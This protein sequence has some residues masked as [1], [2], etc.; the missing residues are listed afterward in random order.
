MPGPLEEVMARAP[1]TEAPRTMLIAA[2][3]LSDWMNTPSM[4]A[5]RLA[6]YSVSSFWGVMG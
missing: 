6:M 3:S 1:A 4:S 2:I 5:M